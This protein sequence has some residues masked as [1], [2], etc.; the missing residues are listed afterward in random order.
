MISLAVLPVH[1][2]IV[3]ITYSTCETHAC[4]RTC[5]HSC[6]FTRTITSPR[7]SL[8]NAVESV[9]CTNNY[10]T[11]NLPRIEE[12]RV[13]DCRGSAAALRATAKWYASKSSA[14]VAGE[15]RFWAHLC[16][17][18][19]DLKHLLAGNW[20]WMQGSSAVSFS[21]WRICINYDDVICVRHRKPCWQLLTVHS[22]KPLKLLL[23]QV[24]WMVMPMWMTT[25][26]RHPV[27]F[28]PFLEIAFEIICAKNEFCTQLS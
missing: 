1:S 27:R 11:M 28:F 7:S 4:V 10:G 9:S 5:M 19:T 14:S 16:D 17:Y 12:P 20:T 3:D 22:G 13:A 25:R 23:C 24:I 6:V 8:P 18:S 2:R 26:S 21:I 15:T